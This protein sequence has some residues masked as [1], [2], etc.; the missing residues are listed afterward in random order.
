MEKYTDKI[1]HNC[2]YT[3]AVFMV[4]IEL[5]VAHL[6]TIFFKLPTPHGRLSRPTL[7]NVFC[8]DGI[9]E[10]T[11]PSLKLHLFFIIPDMGTWWF[12]SKDLPPPMQ[13]VSHVF[14]ILPKS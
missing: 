10:V 9:A 1:R 8:M 5:H 4:C 2:T 6:Q 13:V 11:M 7:I 12:I 14:I 3:Y